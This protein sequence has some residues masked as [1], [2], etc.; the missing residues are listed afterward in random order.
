VASRTF[1]AAFTKIRRGIRAKSKKDF[2]VDLR[3][4]I[5]D[6]EDIQG[7]LRKERPSGNR[8]YAVTFDRIKGDDDFSY[9]H[10]DLL[11]V[12]LDAI[13]G[14]NG[15][16]KPSS[17]LRALLWNGSSNNLLSVMRYFTKL[18]PELKVRRIL[19]LPFPVPAV[20]YRLEHKV[21]LR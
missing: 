10:F 12:A 1:A 19:V 5:D 15:I 11:L 3:G 6:D 7:I 20:G 14:G 13:A 18:N 16:Y 9:S 4:Q 2:L 21:Y 8:Y 17:Q